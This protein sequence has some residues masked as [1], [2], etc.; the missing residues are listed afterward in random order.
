MNKEKNANVT[1]YGMLH[2]LVA[3]L[4]F[5][6]E[7]NRILILTNQTSLKKTSVAMYQAGQSGTR[8]TGRNVTAVCGNH[9][10][11]T[12]RGN[13]CQATSHKNIS[14]SNLEKDGN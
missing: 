8:E 10:K 9:C 14:I 3:I 7:H 4:I 13:P 11:T 5:Y 2:P 6:V 12:I 1:A